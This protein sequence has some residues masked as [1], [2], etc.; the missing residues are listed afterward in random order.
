MVRYE[1]PSLVNKCFLP[2]LHGLR[3]PFKPRIIRLSIAVLFWFF[4][5]A[6]ML[7]CGTLASFRSPKDSD[8]LPDIMFDLLPDHKV[9]PLPEVLLY[10]LLFS[11]VGRMI[12]HPDGVAIARR[13]AAIAGCIYIF[14]SFTLIATSLPD[15]LQRCS[16][17]YSP[18]WNVA[19]FF[20]DK[21]GDMMGNTVNAT[22]AALVWSQYTKHRV[23]YVFAWLTSIT[24]M[25]LFI[26]NRSHYTLDV[27]ISIFISVFCWKYYHITLLLP[28]SSQNKLVKWLE[29]LD[30]GAAAVAGEELLVREIRERGEREREG[31]SLSVVTDVLGT[32][33]GP[34]KYRELVEDSPKY[35][36]SIP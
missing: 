23:L 20:T 22:L 5:F 6:F 15:P 12:F 36:H 21:C 1:P 24:A 27:L 17:D 14:R 11:A 10:T 35:N 8:T 30:F 9:Y 13:F 2:L 28:S 18:S 32:S 3:R 31:I 19:A 7:F 25:L 4:T 34:S 26:V 33:P 16:R 29:K